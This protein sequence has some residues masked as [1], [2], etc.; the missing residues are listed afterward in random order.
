MYILQSLSVDDIKPAPFIEDSRS[1]L[2]YISKEVCHHFSSNNGLISKPGKTHARDFVIA[3]W[4]NFTENIAP[5][6]ND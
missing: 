1:L 5:A 4:I 2:D 6:N 3:E